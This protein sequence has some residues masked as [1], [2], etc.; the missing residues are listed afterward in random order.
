M[1][2]RTFSGADERFGNSTTFGALETSL[3][4]EESEKLRSWVRV[5]VMLEGDKAQHTSPKSEICTSF[6]T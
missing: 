4:V 2:L 6:W 1:M 5:V 3:G